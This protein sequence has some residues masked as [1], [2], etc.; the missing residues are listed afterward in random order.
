[1]VD[2][3]WR[4]AAREQ[5]VKEVYRSKGRYG[6]ER[7][8]LRRVGAQWLSSANSSEY[9]PAGDPRFFVFAFGEKTAKFFGF[10]IISETEMI[11][12]NPVEFAGAVRLL[13]Q[14]LKKMGKAAISFDFHASVGV[15]SSEDFLNKLVRNR[16]LPFANNF[17]VLLHDASFHSGSIALPQAVADHIIE[18]IKF[19]VEFVAFLRN[20]Y[21]TQGIAKASEVE[22]A[23]K[24]YTD[25]VARAF[26]YGFAQ[27]NF[28]L[29]DSVQVKM[30]SRDLAFDGFKNS[31]LISDATRDINNFAAYANL[32]S[33]GFN[34]FKEDAA[35]FLAQPGLHQPDLTSLSDVTEAGFMRELKQRR[36]DIQDAVRA[37]RN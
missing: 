15:E 6:G 1:M 27:Q 35:S 14:Q 5:V 25:G 3:N 33:D 8:H 22:Q 17:P 9:A 20:K 7:V 16:S 29:L 23:I 10:Q 19:H 2:A 13:N 36:T 30:A 12:P 28:Q 34:P 18:R 37:I 21:R 11:I 4:K 26:D 31:M 32:K 24:N